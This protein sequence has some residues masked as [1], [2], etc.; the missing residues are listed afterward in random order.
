MVCQ[1]LVKSLRV[2]V[3]KMALPTCLM[4][5]KNVE[6]IDGFCFVMAW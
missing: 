4:A 1:Y 3:V 2:L 5:M 6:N